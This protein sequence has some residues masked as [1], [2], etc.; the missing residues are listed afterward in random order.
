M[1][2][3]VFYFG[4]WLRPAFGDIRHLIFCAV[5]LSIA[6]TRWHL[7]LSFLYFCMFLGW[8]VASL[9]FWLPSLCVLLFFLT[10]VLASS[11]F[12]VFS[13]LCYLHIQKHIHIHIHIHRH[14]HRHRHIHINIQIHIH[15]HISIHIRIKIHKHKHINRT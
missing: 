6:D 2:F 4:P 8:A 11:G 5:F 7:G 13:C 9:G 15:R 12:W 14:R 10:D 1:F 3:C